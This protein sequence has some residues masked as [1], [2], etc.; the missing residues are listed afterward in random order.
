MADQQYKKAPPRKKAQ[1]KRVALSDD[2]KRAYEEMM[3]KRDAD[4][5]T[6]KT[7]LDG[8]NRRA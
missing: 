8:G 3:Q 5:K 2:A 1:V 4:E 6:Y 7:H